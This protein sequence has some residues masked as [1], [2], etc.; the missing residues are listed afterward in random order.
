[1]RIGKTELK[2][3]LMLAPMAGFSDYAM[4]RI[5]REY[6]AEYSVT[7]MVS[8]KAVVYGDKKTEKLARITDTEGP[9]ALQIFGS[10]PP[11][12]AEAAGRLSSPIDSGAAP[13]AID[14][15]MGCPVPK[16]FSNGEG[17]ALMKNPDLIFDIVKAVSQATALPITVKMRLGVDRNN[18]NATECALAAEE[19]GATLITLHGRTRVEMYSGEADLFEIAKVKSAL[20]IP[21][22]AN[23]DIVDFE[24]ANRALRLTGADGL[25]I[26]RGAIGDPFVFARIS[27]A[28]SGKEYTEP[29]LAERK[30]VA[31]RQLCYAIDEKGEDVAVREARKQIAQYFRGFRG[32]AELRAN[33]NRA[34]TLSEVEAAISAVS[35]IG[36]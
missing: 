31:L 16:I 13:V 8:A 5:C 24:S 21:L 11:I 9:C 26:G 29:T 19:G 4:R 36:D 1:L 33:I 35:E 2:Y 10:E 6:G 18:I 14:I 32:S 30:S 34:L 20:H 27:A 3:G 7:E 17:S 25:M 23:G 28:L 12:M 15:N 22:I